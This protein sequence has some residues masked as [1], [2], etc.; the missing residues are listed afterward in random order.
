[1]ALVGNG[2]VVLGPMGLQTSQTWFTGAVTAGRVYVAVCWLRDIST[3]DGSAVTSAVIGVPPGWTLAYAGPSLPTGDPTRWAGV[4]VVLWRVGVAGMESSPSITFPSRVGS[5]WTVDAAYSRSICLGFSGMQGIPAVAVSSQQSQRLTYPAWS[6]SVT[7]H[8]VRVAAIMA[9]WTT[10]YKPA[11]TAVYDYV[12]PLSNHGGLGDTGWGMSVFDIAAA[13]PAAAQATKTTPVDGLALTVVVSDN[14]GPA[15]AVVTSPAPGAADLAA[16]WS[17]SWTADPTQSAVAFRRR[18][19]G[20][21][22]GAWGYWTGTDWA[23]A[24]AAYGALTAQ[25]KAFPAGQFAGGGQLYDIEV[26]YQAPAYPSASPWAGVAGVASWQAPPAGTVAVSPLS[27]SNVTSRT[28]TVTGG[29]AAGT[30]GTV[31]RY[32]VQVIDSG[33]SAVLA[34]GTHTAGGSWTV[35]VASAV[36]NGAVV[37]GRARTVDTAGL[38]GPWVTSGPYTVTVAVPATPTLSV[39]QV[40]HPT[41]G[42]PG[43]AVT[44]TIPTGAARDVTLTRDGVLVATV[45]TSGPVLIRDDGAT[46]TK[47]HTWAAT[48]SDRAAVPNVSA[49][50]TVAGSLSMA[51]GD[52]W[53]WPAGSPGEALLAHVRE[54]GAEPI[55]L[56]TATFDVIGQPWREVRQGVPSAPSGKVAWIVATPAEA[57]A[58]VALLSSGRTLVQRR[59]MESGPDGGVSYAGDVTLRIV[60]DVTT[61][62]LGAP[63][64]QRVVSA[65]W[66]SASG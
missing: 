5:G 45:T 42:L 19:G 13:V 8:L 14:V 52:C 15:A 38:V 32:D 65:S 35:P 46:P 36:A 9:G 27:G 59:W 20:G 4:L 39:A 37:R 60:G 21:T 1:M 41:S 58:L 17:L 64:T 22:P 18:T 49:A 53:V 62:R 57:A 16:A 6:K 11:G 55:D 56:R 44:V 54:W 23:G 40:P 66:E 7:G 34:S 47:T 10:T 3:T 28:P 63:V 48:V 61:D 50:G 2:G 30:S 29:G 31:A 24:S 33:T 25:T 51:G 26:S 12:A 43:L